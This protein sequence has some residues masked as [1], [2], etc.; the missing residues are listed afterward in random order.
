MSLTAASLQFYFA[1][2]HLHPPIPATTSIA[3]RAV[4]GVGRFFFF[5]DLSAFDQFHVVIA[6]PLFPNVV[7]PQWLDLAKD[8]SI[9]HLN[10]ADETAALCLGAWTPAT[11]KK[12]EE[13]WENRVV[14]SHRDKLWDIVPKP[15]NSSAANKQLIGQLCIMY[16]SIYIHIC[17]IY[18]LILL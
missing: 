15:N 6:S 11:G 16:Q 3:I 8:D 17:S 18:Y 13:G 5:F 7:G 1:F 14:S 12:A 10:D 4:M 9:V 2:L